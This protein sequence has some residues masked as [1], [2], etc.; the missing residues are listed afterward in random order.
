M[1]KEPVR[2]EEH[3]LPGGR[4]YRTFRDLPKKIYKSSP[5]YI[6]WL[7]I[8][9]KTILTR[10]HPLFEHTECLFLL[11]WRGNRAV[12][13]IMVFDN[14]RYNRTHG[15]RAAHFFFLDLE[16]DME[17]MKALFERACQW[18]RER[19]LEVL[20]GPMGFGGV[21]GG[22]LLVEGFEERSAMTMMRYNHPYYPDLMERYGF[23]KFM[24][25]HS[26]YLSVPDFKLP[27]QIHDAAEALLEK[28]D[29]GVKLFH[30]KKDMW[31][32]A[33]RIIELYKETL[34]HHPENYLM[35]DSELQLLA[36]DIITIADPELIKILTYRDQVIGFLFA[37]HDLSR[38]IQKSGG[39]LTPLSLV[40]LLREYKKT[41]RVL[42]NGIGILPEYQG[43]GGN[44]LL[45]SEL[46]KTIKGK[47][48]RH[49]EMVLVSE[50]TA[51]MLSNVETL[52]GESLKVH[53][54]FQLTL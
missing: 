51:R 46:E 26:F 4:F 54:I 32:V 27:E 9:M 6:P 33:P 12:G 43:L 24:D 10:R 30:S 44:A 8:D 38:A 3:S 28:G 49:A 16:N 18:A 22:G 50:T 41:D 48:F 35:S 20:L 2:I 52:K 5:Y 15:T 40:R 45:Y 19:K 42:I 34:G 37:F 11:A 39:R 17:V 13:R 1:Q 23:E 14:S 21:T 36:K 29:F 7:N 47:G 53:R 25:L 31:M